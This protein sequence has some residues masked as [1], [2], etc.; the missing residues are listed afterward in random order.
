M[1]TLSFVPKGIFE[2]KPEKSI[3]SAIVLVGEI[4]E[5]EAYA[6]VHNLSWIKKNGLHKSGSQ[7]LNKIYP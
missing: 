6:E 7:Q 1:P 4:E 3:R 5:L 2:A